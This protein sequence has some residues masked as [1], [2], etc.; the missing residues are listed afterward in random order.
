MFFPHTFTSHDIAYGQDVSAG[1]TR[2]KVVLD[3]DIDCFYQEYPSQDVLPSLMAQREVKRGR[4][5]TDD[6]TA[7][8]K[9]EINSLIEIDTGEVLGTI[10]LYRVL[11][12]KNLCGL[13]RLF[14]IEVR[15]DSQWEDLSV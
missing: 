15:E 10:K 12:K 8:N 4:L 9:V 3:Q 2:D 14:K 1:F 7:W 5:Y 6:Q 11:D 13:S